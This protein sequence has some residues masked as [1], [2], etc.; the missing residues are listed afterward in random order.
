[1]RRSVLIDHIANALGD[2]QVLVIVF[3]KIDKLTLLNAKLINTLI[4]I[5]YSLST[6]SRCQDS[7]ER[8]KGD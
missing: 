5:N 8:G 4:K 6:F 3:C 1:L 2:F 7:R